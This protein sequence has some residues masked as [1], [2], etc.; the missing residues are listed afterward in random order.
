VVKYKRKDK[1]K[2]FGRLYEY[3][4]QRGKRREEN[5]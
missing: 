4:R 3:N 5:I 1:R 2:V